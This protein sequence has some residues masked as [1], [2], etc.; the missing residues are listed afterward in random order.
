MPARFLATAALALALLL[1]SLGARCRDAES[2][3]PDRAVAVPD[4][5][6]LT[7]DY[8]GV[9]ALTSALERDSLGDT[10]VDSLLRVHGVRAMV[11]NVTRFVPGVGEPEFRRAVR[12]FARTKRRSDLDRYFGLNEV[13]RARRDMRALVERLR[14]RE[15][16]IQHRLLVQLAP[17]QPNTGPLVASAYFVAGGV[18]TGFV[19]D[20]A[21][22]RMYANLVRAGDDYDGVVDNL[23]HEAYHVMQ[24]AAQ[25]RAGLGAFAD[26]VESQRLPDRLL[27]TTLAEGTAQYIIEA[28]G[29]DGRLPRAGRVRQNFAVLD[30][31]LA[32]L[33]DGSLTWER[34]Y[35]RG[36][37]SEE[38]ERFYVLGQEMTRAI[39]RHC[40]REC[41]A[42]MF[43]QHPAEFFRE[44]VRLYREHPDLVGRFAPATEAFIAAPAT[45]R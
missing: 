31:V 36:F 28:R 39:E 10:D 21:S 5:L 6:R 18:S 37:T 19:P 14:S 29:R 2:P 40:G 32:G 3:E 33:R 16:D 4:T 20:D 7:F 23:A 34:A 15:A 13:W 24:K 8:A 9:E 11:D 17:Y 1:V 42:R 27:A 41:V 35:A 25:R 12:S 44:Y 22:G 26:S 43:E 38:G 45:S 30:T